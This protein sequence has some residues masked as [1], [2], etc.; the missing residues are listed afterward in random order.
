MKMPAFCYHRPT[1]VEEAVGLLAQYGSDAKVLAGGQSLV[2]L[3]ALRLSHPEHLVDIGRIDGL[4]ALDNDPAGFTVG[5]AVRHA[6]VELSPVT[7]RAAPLVAAAMPYI[8]H[9]AIRNRGTVCGS[10][11]HAD[12]AAELPAVAL[13]TD[14]ELV[15]RSAAG[16][17]AIPA[18]DFFLG[19]LTS[20][21]DET[22]LLTAVRF[23]PWPTSTG[24]SVAEVSRRHGDYA[25]VGLA[26]VV[27]VGDGG[28]IER[29]ALSFFGAGATPVRVTEAEQVLVG[30]HPD[31][32]LFAEAADVV[33]KAIEPPGDNHATAAYRAHVAGVL[34]R[35][36][37]AEAAGRATGG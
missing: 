31:P 30:E 33:A 13:A 1:T 11:A 20:A 28:R 3:L 14:A 6:D 10:L 29:A 37:L 19:Y 34:T 15:V 36:C 4:S 2:P 12:P 26:A 18:A 35:R 24:G 16:E 21:L 22:E 8:G 32:A 25:L 23:P 27:G 5:A 9:R 7:G 17:R